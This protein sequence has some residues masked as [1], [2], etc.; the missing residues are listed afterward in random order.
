MNCYGHPLVRFHVICFV[1]DLW[2]GLALTLKGELWICLYFV[3][4]AD[5]NHAEIQ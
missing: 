3:S 4:V 1:S 2:A 5:C